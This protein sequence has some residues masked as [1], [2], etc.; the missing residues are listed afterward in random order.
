PSVIFGDPRG[1]MEFATQLFNDM[2]RPPIP[3]VSFFSGINPEK[4]AVVMSPVHVEDV[5]SAFLAA[6][7]ND[8]SIGQTYVLGGPEVLTWKE[9][10][11]RIAAATGR[12]KWSLP[13]PI[14]LMRFGAILFDWLPFFPVTREQLT[15][16]AE[17]NIADPQ[18]IKEL[19]GHEPR[20]FSV[21]TLEY[22]NQ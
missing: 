18:I 8:E 11:S 4:G 10:V 12:R 15:M 3:A 16:L 6:L 17:G 19:T 9:M 13:M 14:A 21:E 20:P 5:A 22:L 1:L 2:V 7:E